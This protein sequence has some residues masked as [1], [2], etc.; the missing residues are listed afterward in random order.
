MIPLVL[1][2]FVYCTYSNISAYYYLHFFISFRVMSDLLSGLASF[3]KTVTDTLNT[4]EIRKL[5][6]KV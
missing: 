6:G 5:G 1:T 3:T 2:N 4:Y